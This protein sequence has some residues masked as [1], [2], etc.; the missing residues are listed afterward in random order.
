MQPQKGIKIFIWNRFGMFLWN[1]KQT[2]FSASP[3]GNL[4]SVRIGWILT[5]GFGTSKTR[6]N[7]EGSHIPLRLPIEIKGMGCTTGTVFLK[8]FLVKLFFFPRLR[9]D[10]SLSNE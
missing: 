1:Q 9:L 8:G 5:C 10:V 4:G 6:V 7:D 2:E 3:T